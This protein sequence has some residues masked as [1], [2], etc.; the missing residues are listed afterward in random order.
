MVA[1][2][3]IQGLTKASARLESVDP[4]MAQLYDRLAQQTEQQILTASQQGQQQVP[5]ESPG[6]GPEVIPAAQ[7]EGLNDRAAVP[8]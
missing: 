3:L 1:L 7:Q 6:V 4:E 8:A 5:S 2:D